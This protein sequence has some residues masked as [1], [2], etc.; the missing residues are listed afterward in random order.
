MATINIP[1]TR[2]TDVDYLRKIL[3]TL[4]NTA[5]GIG[6]P[7]DYANAVAAATAAGLDPSDPAVLSSVSTAAS[8]VGGFTS[9]INY[10]PAISAESYSAGDALGSQGVLSKALRAGVCTGL[11]QSITVYDADQQTPDI[12]FLFFSRTL[13][14]LPVDDAQYS[15]TA[16]DLDYFLGAASIV[17]TDYKELATGAVATLGNVGLV[18]K[19]PLLSSGGIAGTVWVVA[20]TQSTPTFTTTSSLRFTFGF[21]QD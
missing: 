13:A 16:P 21:L 19:V 9:V 4:N 6:S 10:T 2:D 12:D 11:L 5:Y 1:K 14:T 18:L 3:W 20:V 15:I 7:A 8:R 17:S